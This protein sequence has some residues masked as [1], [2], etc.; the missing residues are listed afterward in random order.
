[1]PEMANAGEDHR[2]VAFIRSGDNFLVAN[3]A[4]R[5]NRA[6]RAGIGRLECR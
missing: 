2:H 3:R 4:A 6:S 5:L 1:M